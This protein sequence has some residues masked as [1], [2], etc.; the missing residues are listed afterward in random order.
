M[1]EYKCRVAKVND[2][3]AVACLDTISFMLPRNLAIKHMLMRYYADKNQIRK[4]LFMRMIFLLQDI[5]CG[6]KRQHF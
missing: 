5:K 4:A 2:D 1:M 3:K 6:L